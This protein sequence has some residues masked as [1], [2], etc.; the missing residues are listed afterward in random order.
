MKK[1]APLGAAFSLLPLGIGLVLSLDVV[2]TD[3]DG[4]HVQWDVYLII[5][6]ALGLMA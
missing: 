4:L 2:H 6:M 1:A 3:L 5:L